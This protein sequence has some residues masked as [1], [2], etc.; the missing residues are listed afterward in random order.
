MPAID[1]IGGINRTIDWGNLVT[2]GEAT[3]CTYWSKIG[4]TPTM[5]TAES[6]VWSAAGV[7]AFPAAGGIQAETVAQNGSNQ[8]IL[9]SPLKFVETVDTFVG[10]IGTASGIA[11]SY[12]E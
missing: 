4:Y 5:T 3:G 2:L 9:Q 10:G 7:Y 1:T 12:L 8:L 6:V 11:T